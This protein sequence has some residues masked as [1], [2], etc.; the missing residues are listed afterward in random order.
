MVLNENGT[1]RLAGIKP[2]MVAIIPLVEMAYAWV[3]F[4]CVITAGT[5]V[6]DSKGRRYHMLKSK[7]ETGEALDFRTR[8]LSDSDVDEL[9]RRVGD[10]LT[11]EYQVIR[12]KGK[13]AHMHIEFDPK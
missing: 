8:G 12:H 1:V 7:H 6:F 3:N 2:E 4:P 10:L 11:P 5:E 13:F 9:Y